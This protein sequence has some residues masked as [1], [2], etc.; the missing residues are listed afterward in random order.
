MNTTSQIAKHL[1][2]FHFGGNWTGV[3]LKEKIKDVS[4][5]ESITKVK[6]FHNIATLIFHMDFYIDASIT[7]LEG[8]PLEAADEKSFLFQEPSNEE[9]WKLLLE[10]TWANARKL[11][12]LVEFLPEEKLGE[13]FESEKN[14]IYYRCL[15]GIIEHCHYHLGQISIIKTLIRS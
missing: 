13:P 12:D 6:S 15:H 14:G 7:F 5:E 4:F 2:E 9:E 10:S 8:G 1:R 11:A 3:S